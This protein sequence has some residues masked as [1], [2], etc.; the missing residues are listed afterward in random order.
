M[1]GHAAAE[2]GKACENA[3]FLP[4]Q[5]DI[6]DQLFADVFDRAHTEADI[7]AVD[8]EMLG[9]AVDVRRQNRNAHRL[10][11]ADIFGDLGGVAEHARQKRTHVFLRIVAF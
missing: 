5:N 3:V 2:I 10:A 7:L 1:G 6:G 11:L 4:L 8:G 9:G